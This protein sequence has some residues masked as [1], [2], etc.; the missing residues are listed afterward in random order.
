[1][2]LS[3]ERKVR[4]GFTVGGKCTL[5]HLPLAPSGAA[6]HVSQ[7]GI[8]AAIWLCSTSKQTAAVPPRM[9]LHAIAGSTVLREEKIRTD[10][11]I[12]KQGLI[13][14]SGCCSSSDCY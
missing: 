11:P 14:F 1:M 13:K 3:Q 5:G 10:F 9:W 2:L 6:C 7:E 12:T 8:A 4:C